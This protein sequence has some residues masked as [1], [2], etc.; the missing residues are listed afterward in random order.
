MLFLF[1]FSV[2]LIFFVFVLW[3]SVNVSPDCYY[4]PQT[5]MFFIVVVAILTFFW[6]FKLIKIICATSQ[7]NSATYFLSFDPQFKNI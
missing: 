2:L 7:R 1:L 3:R 4:F 5:D 6:S